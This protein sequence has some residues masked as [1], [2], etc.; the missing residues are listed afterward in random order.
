MISKGYLVINVA[1]LSHEFRSYA[2]SLSLRKSFQRLASMGTL[3]FNESG[4][5]PELSE[6]QYPIIGRPMASNSL[7]SSPSNSSIQCFA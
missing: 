2:Q 5:P 3:L 1:V 4:S 6:Q 7:A